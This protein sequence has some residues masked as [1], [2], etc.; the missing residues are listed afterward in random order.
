[1]ALSRAREVSYITLA[2]RSGLKLHSLS[3]LQGMYIFGNKDDLAKRSTMWD[4]VISE[5]QE[6]DAV[7]TALPIACHQHPDAVQYVSQ[8]GQLPQIAPDGKLK[9]LT[10]HDN[11]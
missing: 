10:F 8:P 3:L 11:T 5:L 1:M 6:I 4:K 7:G 9:H 2:E